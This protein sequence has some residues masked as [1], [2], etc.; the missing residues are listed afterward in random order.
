M[1]TR[2]DFIQLA[3]TTANIIKDCN[4]ADTRLKDV[5]LCEIVNFCQSQNALFD[6]HRFKNAIEKDL[7]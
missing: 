6:I 1:M 7:K 3:R 4:K 5:V 2:K